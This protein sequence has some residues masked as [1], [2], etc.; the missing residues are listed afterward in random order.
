MWHSMIAWSCKWKGLSMAGFGHA[1]K[2]MASDF[3]GT[4]FFGIGGRVH[5]LHRFLPRDLAAIEE[6]RVEGGLFGVCTGRPLGAV[7]DDAGN[8]LSFDFA[9]TSS[10]A[11]VSDAEGNTLFSREIPNDDVRAVLDVA[12]GQTSRPSFLA[13]K[14]GYLVLGESSIPGLPKAFLKRLRV[15]SSVD[16]ALSV[17]P[18]ERGESVQVV[19]LGFASQERAASFVAGVGERLGGR[20]AAFQNL[21]SVDVVPAGC[22]KGT[23]LAIARERFGLGLVGG[24]GDSFNDLPLLG[25]AD[26][27]YTFN[28]APEVVRAGADVLVDDVAEA[29]A[30]FERRQ[31]VTIGA[32]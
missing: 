19:S 18:G 1:R 5:P 6:F 4:L 16:E 11:C 20:V 3:D 12:H 7:L 32:N 23:G 26:V 27:A 25:E 14:S 30:D 31:M 8:A 2:A 21:N 9:V 28:R 15:V 24:I 17:E 29:L 10:G 22:S 13:V